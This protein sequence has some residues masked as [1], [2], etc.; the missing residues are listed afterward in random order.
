MVYDFL[1]RSGGKAED[2]L[3]ILEIPS[4]YNRIDVYSN[5][6]NKYLICNL[7]II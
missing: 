2:T 3:F 7:I 4:A 6:F 1:F 5:H